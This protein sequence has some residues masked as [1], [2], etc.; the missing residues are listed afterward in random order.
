M[1]EKKSFGAYLEEAQ[2]EVKVEK[3]VLTEGAKEL[4]SKAQEYLKKQEIK[5]ESVEHFIATLNDLADADFHELTIEELIICVMA[6][7]ELDELQAHHKGAQITFDALLN[8]VASIQEQAKRFAQILEK[9]KAQ[10]EK[11]KPSK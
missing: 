6:T 3:V 4:A 1:A 5:K 10:K 2:K 8:S 9:V 11:D 7:E